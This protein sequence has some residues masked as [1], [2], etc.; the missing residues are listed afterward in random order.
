MSNNKPDMDSHIISIHLQFRN[1]LTGQIL[2]CIVLCIVCELAPRVQIDQEPKTC[3]KKPNPVIQSWSLVQALVQVTNSWAN[4]EKSTVLIKILTWKIKTHINE[5]YPYKNCK[6]HENQKKMAFSPVHPLVN[7][8]SIC[9]QCR[10][11]STH[12]QIHWFRWLSN[13]KPSTYKINNYGWWKKINSPIH[14]FLWTM[15]ISLRD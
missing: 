5:N 10:V 6:L 12:R 4:H 11:K 13:P 9:R 1:F 7:G 14:V 3:V 2:S 15:V 8:L